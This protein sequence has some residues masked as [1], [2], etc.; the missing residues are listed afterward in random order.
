MRTHA[1]LVIN[2]H[3]AALSV[4][5]SVCAMFVVGDETMLREMLARVPIL[6]AAGAPE[7]DLVKI[8]SAD[9]KTA[10]ALAPL[11]VALRR[12]AG[13]P[14][15]APAEVL[16]VAADICKNIEE[17]KRLGAGRGTHKRNHS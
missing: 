11:V 12:L 3:P 7:R 8:L 14:V 16:E 15:R 1:L 5:Q 6:I 13:E 9:S 10:D 2:E 4:F 17:A